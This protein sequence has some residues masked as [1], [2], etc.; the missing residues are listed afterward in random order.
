MYLPEEYR[1]VLADLWDKLS[2][3]EEFKIRKMKNLSFRALS[4]K[5]DLDYADLN[6]IEKGKRNITLTTI[7]ELARGLNVHPKELFDF[8]FTP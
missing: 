5:C 7:A 2:T 6:K 4:Q 8:D 1:N 3:S